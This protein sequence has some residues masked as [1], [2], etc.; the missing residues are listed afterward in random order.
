MI[1]IVL[2][3]FGHPLSSSN[4][5]M[6]ANGTFRTLCQPRINAS[7]MKGVK[8]GYCSNH[9]TDLVLFQT[10]CTTTCCRINLLLLLLVVVLLLKCSIFNPMSAAATTAASSTA[11]AA[12]TAAHSQSEQ[13]IILRQYPRRTP[14]NLRIGSTNSR[15]ERSKGWP[16][17]FYE[18]G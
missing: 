14:I 6:F 12:T 15:E 10:N 16:I 4:R 17:L 1:Y 2:L 9:F 11:A 18:G 3:N 8:A 5:R 13:L 7:C